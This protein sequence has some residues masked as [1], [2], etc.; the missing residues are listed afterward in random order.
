[1]V[2][3]RKEIFLNNNNSL[4]TL[5]NHREGFLFYH[6]RLVWKHIRSGRRWRMPFLAKL[7]SNS[8]FSNGD[9]FAI[10][11]GKQQPIHTRLI[12]RCGKTSFI[13]FTLAER[14]GS[15]YTGE[16][17]VPEHPVLCLE[18]SF[19]DEEKF[20]AAKTQ[21][22]RQI[23]KLSTAQPLR[24]TGPIADYTSRIGNFHS[25]VIADQHHQV[26]IWH[27][28]STT[29]NLSK[30]WFMNQAGLLWRAESLLATHQGTA[31]EAKFH[32]KEGFY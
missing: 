11:Q 14:P 6:L 24:V 30:F 3:D 13:V 17:T 32:L 10:A 26:V 1:M 2:W 31:T 21:V 23:C 8:A 29:G 7:A 16:I 19:T 15:V 12:V 4:K 5:P 9:S 20:L 22:L 25:V 28:E 27:V 18:G